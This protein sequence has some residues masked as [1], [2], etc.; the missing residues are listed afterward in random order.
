MAY[1]GCIYKGWRPSLLHQGLII[2][3]HF[4][5]SVETGASAISEHTLLRPKHWLWSWRSMFL[6]WNP[7]K[8]WHNQHD[9]NTYI[10]YV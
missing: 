7:E 3:R 1:N 2:L 5:F 9:V 4:K 6:C 8:L 10:S